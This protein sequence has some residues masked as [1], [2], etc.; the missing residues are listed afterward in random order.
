MLLSDM[1]L[2]Y[3]LTRNLSQYYYTANVLRIRD[4]LR[5]NILVMTREILNQHC[6][7]YS[8]NLTLLCHAML[9][10]AR[11]TSA[12]SL[13]HYWIMQISRFCTMHLHLTHA[14]SPFI[15]CIFFSFFFFLSFRWMVSLYEAVTAFYE[16]N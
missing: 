14:S 16:I 12:H 2:M 4:R 5:L 6:P 1:F 7:S 3:P 13:K 10:S 11:T 9:V 8:N 15:V